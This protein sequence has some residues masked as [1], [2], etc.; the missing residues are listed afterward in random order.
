MSQFEREDQVE[1]DVEPGERTP[2]EL[3]FDIERTRERMSNNIDALGEKLSPGN[4]KRQ[5]KDAIAEKAQDAVANVGDHARQTGSR[6]IDFITENPLSVAAAGLGAVWLISLRK[7][8]RSEVS[9]DIMEAR[10]GLNHFMAEKPLAFAA[11]AAIIGIAL[12]VL[13][14]ETESERSVMGEPRDRLANRVSNA[15]SRVKASAV[16]AGRELKDSVRE[17]FESR[18]PEIKST[19]KDAVEHV[20]DQVKESASRVKEEAKQVARRRPS[21]GRKG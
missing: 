8:S 6:V 5:A 15:A 16:E 20:K 7:R 11:G 18:A 10:G 14:P 9:G 17:A 1:R 13:L 19:L 3:E 21:S 12:G 2:Q 4:L